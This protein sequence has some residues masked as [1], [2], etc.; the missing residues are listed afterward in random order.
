MNVALL[1]F[2]GGFMILIPIMYFGALWHS[3]IIYK[4][5][6]KELNRRDWLS[7]IGL[8]ETALLKRKRFLK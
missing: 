5:Q 3:Q 8:H 6:M 4:I 2:V 1:L 7:T